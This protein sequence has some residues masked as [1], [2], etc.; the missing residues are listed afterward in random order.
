MSINLPPRIL[1]VEADAII[2]RHLQ[3]VLK[4]SGYLVQAVVDNGSDAILALDQALPNLALVDLQ[5]TGTYDGIQTAEYFQTRHQIPI[6]FLT[7]FGAD[8]LLQRARLTN[9]FGYVTKPFEER[10][11]QATVELALQKAHFERELRASRERYLAVIAQASE[12]IILVDHETQQVIEN[13]R[14]FEML[15]GLPQTEI[16]GHHLH[17][18]L[19]IPTH[20]LTMFVDD[21]PQHI[22]D[23]EFHRRDGAVLFLDITLTQIDISGSSLVCVMTRDLTERHHAN[24]EL[25]QMHTALEEL[26]HQRTTELAQSNRQLHA[27]LDSIP[28]MAW[29]KDASGHFLAVNQRMADS[30]GMSVSEILGKTDLD[31]YP[32]EIAEAYQRDDQQVIESG[33]LKRV[34]ERYVTRKGVESW[35]ET[36]KVPVF[37]DAAQVMGTAGVARDISQRKQAETV[38]RRSQAELEQLVSERTHALEALNTQL[39]DEIAQ[40]QRVENEYHEFFENAIFGIYQ[41]SLQGRYNIVNPAMAH[42]FGYNTPEEMRADIT[43]IS[44]QIYAKPGRRQEYLELIYQTNG[45]VEQENEYRRRDGTRFLGLSY[46]QLVRNS[47]GQPIQIEGFLQD[48]TARRQA[49]LANR[50]S[51]E[52]Y[53]YIYN[54]TP[55]MLHSIDAQGKLT[56]VS[57]YWLEALNYTR[58]EVLGRPYIDFI[59]PENHAYVTQLILPTFFRIGICKDVPLQI[60]KKNGEVLEVQLS[61]VSERDEEGNIQ[62]SLSVFVDITERMRAEQQLQTQVRRMA[63]L[64]AVEMSITARIDL[65]TTLNTL[66]DQ[67]MAQ[68]G[69]DASCVLLLNPRTQVLE[70]AADRGFR[71]T[72]IKSTRLRLGEGL[73]GLAAQERRLVSAT[74]LSSQ[75]EAQQHYVPYLQAEGFVSYFGMPLI[76]KGLVKGVLEIYQRSLLNPPREWLEFLEALAR[77]AAIAI[78]NITLFE[79]QQRA[80]QKLTEAFDATI[81]GWS[82]G[83]EL[84][85]KVTQKHTTEVT[86]LTLELAQY[87]GELTDDQDHLRRGAILHD[88]GKMGIPDEIL[89]KEGPLTP[90]EWQIMRMHPVYAFEWL[91]PIE[92]LRPALDIPYCH[93]ERWDGNGYPRGLKGN[94]IPLAARIFSVVDVY[95]ALTSN[96]PYRSAM[97]VA[98]VRHYLAQQSGT[99]FEPRIVKAF[100]EMLNEH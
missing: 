6:V 19:G 66:L 47:A 39:R 31:F 95:E 38:L 77:Q 86:R 24:Q 15:V 22:S 41:S 13:N 63:S 5:L 27:L 53:R 42:M 75:L 81:E 26:V 44:A 32:K 18:L 29:L 2:A 36:V 49:E 14:A 85:D 50:S 82:R 97:A 68:L 3:L 78:D 90:E 61:A 74:N 56:S 21:H 65:H 28:D 96:R 72:V 62:R 8:P 92:F 12:G 60:L 11:L 52:R 7:S 17:S 76:V 57:D 59:A 91:S 25:R 48:I 100:L 35:I 70:D 9:P 51:E 10:H 20:Q 69:V 84:R 73:A 93:H 55:S 45:F 64:R 34:E 71:T 87:L 30:C 33:Q 37:N 89:S 43:D 94:Q 98:E 54:T 46:M 67:V 40:R 79:E 1:I 88:I 16:L 58:E 23:M 83:L 80:H 4:K 99:F